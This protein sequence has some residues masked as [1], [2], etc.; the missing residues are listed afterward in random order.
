M[1]G[2]LWK[3]AKMANILYEKSGSYES[4]VQF[5][6]YSKLAEDLFSIEQKFV[7]FLGAGASLPKSPSLQTTPL[8]P[9]DQE[10]I[11]RLS[12]SMGLA[13]DISTIL[14]VAAV[15]VAKYIQ[16]HNLAR[17]QPPAGQPEPVRTSARSASELAGKLASLVLYDLFEEPAR[18][19]NR[20]LPDYQQNELADVLRSATALTGIAPIAPPLLGIASFYQ[21]QQGRTD[22][23]NELHNCFKNVID[24]N[25][26]HRLVAC[27]AKYYIESNPQ[28]SYLSVTTNYD[29]LLEIAMTR[30]EVPHCVVTVPKNGPHVR[31]RF[32][33]DVAGYLGIS[34]EALARLEELQ[35]RLSPDEYYLMPRKPI[36]V[37]YKMHGCLDS[38]ERDKDSIVISDEDY[39]ETIGAS[40]SNSR[41][42]PNQFRTLMGYRKFLFLGY[43]FSDW[44]V[45]ILYKFLQRLRVDQNFES[46]DYAVFN[47]VNPYESAFF[48]EKKIN[49]CLTNLDNFSESIAKYSS[50]CLESV[51]ETV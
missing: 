5:I 16:E 13:D 33:P 29:D 30:K 37:V 23:W 24:T 22:L 44:N 25:P 19:L 9:I 34:S 50:S 51:S 2:S 31:T 27:A 46:S 8:T 47:R 38:T 4:A 48:K 15:R 7:P 3:A 20:L 14:V 43:S 11:K 6:P 1:V 28:E 18:T 40:G 26:V 41:L 32:S 45:R 39:I 42:V 35:N 12:E 36:A 21:Y 10:K 17:K 49:I